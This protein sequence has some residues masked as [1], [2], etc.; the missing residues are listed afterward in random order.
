M[1]TDKPLQIAVVGSGPSGCFLAQALNR[2]RPNDIIIVFDQLAAPYGLIRY[3][4]ATDHQ[5][6]KSI[7]R[8]F[9]RLFAK[10]NVKFA[11]NI[12]IGAD[13]K[14]EDLR[15]QFDVV[16]LATGRPNARQLDVPGKDLE[17]VYTAADLIYSLNSFRGKTDVFSTLGEHIVLVGGGNVALDIL[18]FLIKEHTD[19][20][21]SDINDDALEAYLDAPVKSVTVLNRSS[22]DE[23][24]SDS[25]MLRELGSI[26]GVRFSSNHSP[27]DGLDENSAAARRRAAVDSL[28]TDQPSTPRVEVG[29]WFSTAPEQFLGT[30]TLEAIQIH[31]TETHESSEIHADSVITAVGFEADDKSPIYKG[32]ESLMRITEDSGRIEPG[33]YRT[34]WLKRGAVGTIPA[35]RACAQDVAKEILADIDGNHI[36]TA[37]EKR[38]IDG[39]RHH[40]AEDP[41]SFAQWVLANEKELSLAEVNRVRKKFVGQQGIIDQ[42]TTQS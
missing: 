3:G 30:D 19:Y 4:V 35:N 20:D 21:G 16:A 38:G 11:G 40:L 12:E 7:T 32:H 5:Q 26:E 9:D 10:E 25:A 34:G 39:L 14:I 6:T 36:H 8:Q 18:R 28:V 2:K 37:T 31:E 41:I 42:A 13:I 27:K 23:A 15:E 22:I 1:T 17:G 24:K 33:L 29:F